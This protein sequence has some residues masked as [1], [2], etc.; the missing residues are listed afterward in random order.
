METRE[1]QNDFPAIVKRGISIEIT[2]NFGFHI[3]EHGLYRL[4][5]RFRLSDLSGFRINCANHK[6]VSEIVVF[7]QSIIPN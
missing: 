4:R 5:R 3:V 1:G 2:I 6:R 7:H